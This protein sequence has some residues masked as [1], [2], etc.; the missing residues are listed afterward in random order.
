MFINMYSH[1]N[2]FTELSNMYLQLRK[3]LFIFNTHFILQRDGMVRG[4]GWGGG[5][6]L[7][8]V[9]VGGSRV[10][11]LGGGGGGNLQPS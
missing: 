10:G 5:W 4:R 8:V 9:V 2:V 6:G 1:C 11:G 3:T 7:V